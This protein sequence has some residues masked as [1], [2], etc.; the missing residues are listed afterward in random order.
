MTSDTDPRAN[1]PA[2][3]DDNISEKRAIINQARKPK[4][5]NG[6]AKSKK[7]NTKQHNAEPQRKIPDWA[8]VQRTAQSIDREW[9]ILPGEAKPSSKWD[10]NKLPHN[11][12]YR[13]SILAKF[14]G[15]IQQV[16][17][18]CIRSNSRYGYIITDKE[19]LAVRVCSLPPD[20]RAALDDSQTS[21]DSAPARPEIRGGMEF[22]LIPWDNDEHQDTEDSKGLTVNLALWWLHMMAANG[23]EVQESYPPLNHAGVNAKKPPKTPPTRFTRGARRTDT[24]KSLG[25][26]S[27]EIA[28]GISSTHLISPTPSKPD[29]KRRREDVVPSDGPRKS[30]R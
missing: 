18:Y 25:F 20:S 28:H 1:Y 4:K 17:T 24:T 5:R 3:D 12:N 8:G 16:Y 6:G 27:S 13:F 11:R 14:L 30:R 21:K 15:P 22:K 26:V 9:N 7:R 19:L 2:T 23:T 10:R 29:K